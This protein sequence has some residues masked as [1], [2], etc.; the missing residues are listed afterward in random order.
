MEVQ[1]QHLWDFDL[2]KPT[3]R[4]QKLTT[5]RPPWCPGEPAS[6]QKTFRNP[7]TPWAVQGA[8]I[9]RSEDQSG[10]TIMMFVATALRQNSAKL[11]MANIALEEPKTD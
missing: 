3:S 5:S 6:N 7:A 9:F 1:A 11:I 8:T 4:M 2:E 10:G